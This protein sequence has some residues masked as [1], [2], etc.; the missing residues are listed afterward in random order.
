MIAIERHT[1]VA[2]RRTIAAAVASP[3][4][5]MAIATERLQR[6]EPEAG[7]ERADASAA[8]CTMFA[9]AGFADWRRA[10]ALCPSH[11]GWKGP[12]GRHLFRNPRRGVFLKGF[13]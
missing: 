12:T 3:F 13:F 7:G 9:R 2:D 8:G 6:P 4:A 1:V 5:L 11:R 10:L